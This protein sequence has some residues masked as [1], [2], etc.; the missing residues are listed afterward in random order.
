MYGE[1]LEKRLLSDGIQVVRIVLADGEQYKD[2]KTLNRIFDAMLSA[3]CDRA[4]TIL[5]LGGGVIGDLAG[6]AAATYQ[7]GIAFIQIPTTL[8]AMVDS[9]V[10]GKTAINH[11]LG[12]NMIGAFHQPVAVMADTTC[13]GTLPAREYLSGLAEVIKYGLILD[14]EFFGW[15]EQNL[16]RLVAREPQA[17]EYAI[18]RSCEIK[19]TIVQ[20]DERET[21]PANGRAVLNLGHTF[22]HAIEAALGYGSWLHGEAVACGMVMAARFSAAKGLLAK[23]DADRISA[24]LVR[25]GLPILPPSIETAKMVDLMAR[26]KKNSQDSITLVLLN[27]IGGATTFRTSRESL[28][29]FFDG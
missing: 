25:A 5:A 22:G 2:W 8:L 24:V 20:T 10:G 3:R 7:R 1:A 9:S 14:V 4:T 27:A 26:D 15:I 19:A 11:A 16:D 23:S 12:K 28:F 18:Q 17:V 21:A 29:A 13:L 6:F